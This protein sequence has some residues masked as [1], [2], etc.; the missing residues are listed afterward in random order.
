LNRL[1]DWRI[2][3]T[4]EVMPDRYLKI[5]LTVIALELFWLGIKDIGTPAAA[6][7]TKAA[8]QP[9]EPMPVVIKAI[10]ITDPERIAADPT[11]STMPVYATREMP[12]YS[13]RTLKI[14][15]DRPLAIV[16]AAPLKVQADKPLPVEADKPLPVESAPYK[17]G[18][19]PGE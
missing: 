18:R 6:Q 5:V 8:A 15:A 10:D 17:P 4:E 16:G 13:S 3:A 9:A 11:R 12:V 19:T 1:P 14:D 2:D 7:V